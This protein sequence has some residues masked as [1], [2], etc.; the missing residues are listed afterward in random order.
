MVRRGK[1][2]KPGA[3]HQG[4]PSKVTPPAA[5]LQG[6]SGLRSWIDIGE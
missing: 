1:K 4:F 5:A 2:G 3:R 6:D